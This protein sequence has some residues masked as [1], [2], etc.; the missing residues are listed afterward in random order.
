M[1]K[2][3]MIIGGLALAVALLVIGCTPAPPVTSNFNLIFRYGVGA[4]NELNTFKGTY[5]KDMIA[6]PPITVPL[7]LSEEELDRIYQ[8]MAEI[9]FFAYP[10]EFS[11][12]VPPG[13]SV[14]MVTP[15]SSYYF[16]VEYD[17][18]LKELRWEANIINEDTKA[19]RLRD[20]IKLIGDIIESREEYKQ[21][22]PA[23]GGYM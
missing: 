21:L 8:K 16:K 20:L 4:R 11:I 10:D 2:V 22:P 14:G 6:D 12:S 18:K 3:G 23:S 9:D 15:Y 19:D 7:R 13:E 5:T 17:S 1:R